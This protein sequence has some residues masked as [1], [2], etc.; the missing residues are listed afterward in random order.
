MAFPFDGDLD[1]GSFLIGIGGLLDYLC[2]AFG[3]VP[4][5]PVGQG[6]SGAFSIAGGFGRGAAGA[7][8][9]S[10]AAACGQHHTG[11]AYT[12]HCLQKFACF[13]YIN[14]KIAF[15]RFFDYCR[16]VR[17]FYLICWCLKKR[18]SCQKYI[19]H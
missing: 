8:A 7:G 11:C 12:A 15:K 16:K 10:V 14:C 9:C 4:H 5:R 18:I 19:V 1:A 3:G 2:L 13:Y 6:L 17:G